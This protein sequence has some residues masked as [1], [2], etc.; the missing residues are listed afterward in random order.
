MP[1]RR[2]VTDTAIG[3]AAHELATKSVS[4]M[5]RDTAIAWGA[6]AVATYQGAL[7][8]QEGR[9]TVLLIQAALFKHEALE[10]ASHLGANFLAE[11]SEE[12]DDI[13]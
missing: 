4:Q 7:K 13:P 10:H 1:S 6:R 11:I 12:L 2:W 8:A 9:G 5:E 3:K